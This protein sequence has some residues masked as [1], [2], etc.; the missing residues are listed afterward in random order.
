MATIHLSVDYLAPAAA[1][2]WVEAKVELVKRTS[3]LVFTQALIQ[4]AGAMVARTHAIYRHRRSPV[5][6][7]A[8]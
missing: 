5:A 2:A 6:E 1:G 8:S 4:V 7:P 3:T